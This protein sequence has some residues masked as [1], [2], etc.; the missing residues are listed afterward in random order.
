LTQTIFPEPSFLQLP[1]LS[2]LDIRQ[3]FQNN[4]RSTIPVRLE[5][6]LMLK[7]SLGSPLIINLITPNLLT[8]LITNNAY[9]G[10]NLT[11]PC[12]GQIIIDLL[13]CSCCS[14]TYLSLSDIFSTRDLLSIMSV[15]PHVKHL[16]IN[17]GQ[18]LPMWEHKQDFTLLPLLQ[19][20][21]LGETSV[22]EYGDVV[23]I[24]ETRVNFPKGHAGSSPAT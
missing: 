7:Y 17:I 2:E 1:E 19:P 21:N 9:V 15:T 10:V 14:I 20:F 24:V 16:D 11:I 13:Q 8:L 22:N 3:L 5:P 18:R 4:N 6:L 12:D 23:R